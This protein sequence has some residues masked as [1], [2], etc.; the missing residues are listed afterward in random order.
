MMTSSH[1]RSLAC[2]LAA[3]LP[4][5]VS[6]RTAEVSAAG[7]ITA[8]EVLDALFS[9]DSRSARDGRLGIESC[10]A[11]EEVDAQPCLASQN[12]TF[13]HIPKNAG[14]TIEDL[15]HEN[16]VDWGRH[17]TWDSCIPGHG[18]CWARWHEPPALLHDS[19]PYVNTTVFCV[20]R[21]PYDRIISEYKYIYENPAYQ[22]GNAPI[23]SEYGCSERGLNDWIKSVL[24]SFEGG[25]TYLEM[26]HMLPQSFYIWGPPDDAGNQCRYCNE[27]LRLDGLTDSFNGLMGRLNYTMRMEPHNHSNSGGCPNL[28]KDRL[29]SESLQMIARVYERDFA[30]LNYT[31]L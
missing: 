15:A 12:L 7:A 14:T 2:L 6:A 19:S 3:L 25:E 29:N 8:S 21:D 16:G 22:W 1:R 27:I 17:M 10:Y 5:A 18:Q 30:L 26:C 9:A 13:L 24:T 23:F 31:L 28:G 11:H 4:S 20:T